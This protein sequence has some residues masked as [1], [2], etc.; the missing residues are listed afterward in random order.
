MAY[1]ALTVLSVHMAIALCY[2]GS[3]LWSHIS[4]AALDPFGSLHTGCR[5]RRRADAS[6]AAAAFEN[7][8]SGTRGYRTVN[9]SIMRIQA[10]N[11]PESAGNDVE[12]LFGRYEPKEEYQELEASKAYG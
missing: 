7:T 9:T 2:I 10:K 11:L 5:V 1:L 4:F 8:P 12:T 3:L 6:V